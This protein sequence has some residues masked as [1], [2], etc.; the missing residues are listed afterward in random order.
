MDEIIDGT[1]AF[2][3]WK[4]VKLGTVF[5]VDRLVIQ[6]RDAIV[7][8]IRRLQ[9]ILKIPHCL[10]VISDT[11]P[12]ITNKAL[13]FGAELTVYL[14]LCSVSGI[15]L[16]AILGK[17]SIVWGIIFGLVIP[18]CLFTSVWAHFIFA[19][20][21]FDKGERDPDVDMAGANP[22]LRESIARVMEYV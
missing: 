5:A 12:G 4:G 2:I 16:T 11:A 1:I 7:P 8:K 19:R 3:V 15:T 14:G 6:Y 22:G 21:R 18:M 20:Q 10:S 17:A 13:R 9:S